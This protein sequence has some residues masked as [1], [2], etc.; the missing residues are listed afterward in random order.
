RVPRA[1]LKHFNGISLPR[2]SFLRSPY[3]KSWTVIL[4]KID[5]DLYFCNGWLK[6]VSD[7]SLEA[8]DFLIFIY[9]GKSKFDIKIYGRTCCEK[10]VSLAKKNVTPTSS[11]NDDPKQGGTTKP[12]SM[13]NC[14]E[15][16]ANKAD[17]SNKTK[18]EVVRPRRTIIS[19]VGRKGCIEV[20]YSSK[21][22]KRDSISTTKVEKKQATEATR[23]YISR[24]EKSYVKMVSERCFT[25][26]CRPSR[27]S[28]MTIPNELA[29]KLDLKRMES[30]MLQDPRGELWPVKISIRRNDRIDL[31]KG[32]REF[33]NANG[34]AVGDTC[35]F[36]FLEAKDNPVKVGIYQASVAS[37]KETCGLL[38]PNKISAIN[39]KTTEATEAPSSV[40]STEQSLRSITE[41]H[42]KEANG[43]SFFIK[44]V[45]RRKI[46][47]TVEQ[48]GCFAAIC[49]TSRKKFLTVPKELAAKL[50]LKSKE[51]VML[52]DPHGE[53]WPV[54]INICG[55]G[56]LNFAE[57]WK[58]FWNGNRLAE[59]DTCQFEFM[60]GDDN[61]VKVDI[62]RAG[63]RN[64]TLFSLKTASQ[65]W[66]P[67]S[68]V[69]KRP[70]DSVD[71]GV[72]ATNENPLEVLY[73]SHSRFPASSRDN[74]AGIPWS[75]DGA[76]LSNESACHTETRLKKESC[77]CVTCSYKELVDVTQS[78]RA[79]QIG[80]DNVIINWENEMS[81]I[82]YYDS[83]SKQRKA[84]GPNSNNNAENLRESVPS[85]NGV[86]FQLNSSK[87]TKSTTDVGEALG[88]E[89]SCPTEGFSFCHGVQKTGLTNPSFTVKICPT[90]LK[91]PFV[92]IPISFCINH[93]AQKLKSF[94]LCGPDGRIWEAKFSFG[95]NAYISGGWRAFALEYNMREHDVCSFEMIKVKDEVVLKVSISRGFVE[96]IGTLPADDILLN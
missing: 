53:S 7:H 54:K 68:K 75:L 18:C 52:K 23:K 31:G 92:Q 45:K 9:R 14:H 86:G 33:W 17:V 71:G 50:D 62:F 48:E 1:F 5:N 87:L 10:K 65:S 64:P 32:W 93:L 41:V 79:D 42:R 11:F 84:N 76:V 94:K 78:S 38:K 25:A 73:D 21:S 46:S 26:V 16:E 63:D 36:E 44:P 19:I 91:R 58:S 66:K 22:H 47:I 89:Q 6:F 59:G 77:F 56:R 34:L 20:P 90:Y 4:K 88:S 40:V 2:K 80:G 51:S 13:C 60:Q 96:D 30:V 49:R 27:K 24:R 8:G 57:G 15:N 85:D 72:E 35:Q 43:A 83:S 12:K 39:A 74:I 55:D 69:A 28:H 61:P 3:G 67:R 37:N 82:H 29:A 95:K 81:A 70:A